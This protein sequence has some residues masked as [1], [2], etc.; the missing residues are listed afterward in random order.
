MNVR[1]RRWSGG[2][3][4]DVVKPGVIEFYPDDT[5]TMPLWDQDGLLPTTPSGYDKSWDSAR[6]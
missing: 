5:V 3:D 4:N 1:P 6:N 2:C